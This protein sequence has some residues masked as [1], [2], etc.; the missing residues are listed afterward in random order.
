MPISP[1]TLGFKDIIDLPEWRPLSNALVVSAAGT[2]LAWDPRDH[3]RLPYIF[4]LGGATG[5]YA[6]HVMNDEWLQLG[7]PALSSVAA[8]TS[9]VFHGI[10]PSGSIAAGGTTTSFTLSTALPAA[11]G[12][13]QLAN[14]GDGKGFDVRIVNKVTGKIERKRVVANTGG[15]T[16]TIW[17]DTALASAPN[18]N[19]VYE[20][21]SGR[22]YML[23]A[24]VLAAGTWKYYDVLTNSFSAGLA[25]TNLPA[26]IGTDSCLVALSEDFTPWNQDGDSG[27]LGKLTATAASATTLTGTVAGVDS[28]LVANEYRNFQIRIVQDLTN[29][30]AV[31]QRAR[32]TSHTAGPSPVYTVASWPGGTPSASAQFVIENDNDKI[33]LWSSAVAT[34]FNYN[35]TANT[36]DT[37]TWAARGSAVGAGCTSNQAY[38]PARGADNGRWELPSLAHLE[39]ARR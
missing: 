25:T 32:I 15:T 3:A 28:T 27:F 16:P 10:G 6:Y 18:L 23:G 34:T 7:S 20:F 38:G 5:L 26:T 24:G 37:T 33:I 14:R 13:N 8:G 2:S 29:T 36:W 35:I 31:G 39:H 11:V 12:V 17:I 9:T 21:K 1:T 19:D 22:I 30:S 4:F